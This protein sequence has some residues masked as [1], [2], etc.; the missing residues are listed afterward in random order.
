MEK[1]KIGFNKKIIFGVG[2]IVFLLCVIGIWNYY[3]K[4]KEE[5]TNSVEV[6]IAENTTGEIDL[7]DEVDYSDELFGEYYDEAEELM[8]NMSIEEKVRSIIFS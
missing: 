7:A 5:K 8:K 3:E 2:C 6:K 4:E 1:K